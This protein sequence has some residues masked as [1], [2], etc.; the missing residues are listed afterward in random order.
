MPRF[1]RQKHFRNI[2]IKGLFG[3]ITQRSGP[4]TSAV[5]QFF[6]GNSSPEISDLSIR[7]FR[8]PSEPPRRTIGNHKGNVLAGRESSL[9]RGRNP[10]AV[11]NACAEVVSLVE[12]RVSARISR[13]VLSTS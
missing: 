13:G 7:V 8:G 2:A 4:Q 5:L 1:V 11:R 9:M 3:T 10:P 12:Q 6:S